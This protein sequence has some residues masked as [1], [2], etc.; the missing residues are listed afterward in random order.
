[1]EKIRADEKIGPQLADKEI[2]KV[3]FVQDKIINI[4]VK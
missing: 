3:I 4:I 2:A 1:M